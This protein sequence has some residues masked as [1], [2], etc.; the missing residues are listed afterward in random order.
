LIVKSVTKFIAILVIGLGCSQ[1]L[2]KELP[3]LHRA[4]LQA[5]LDKTRTLL[6][7]KQ[8]NNP[9]QRDQLGST[10][11]HLAVR[12]DNVVLV[13]LLLD[14]GANGNITDGRGQTAMDMAKSWTVW[15]T[16]LRGGALPG[17]DTTI[18]LIALGL[19]VVLG[20]SV[21]LRKVKT[22][23]LLRNHPEAY[24][25]HQSFNDDEDFKDAA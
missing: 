13:K 1:V 12:H 11:L 4:V 9:N 14:E 5:D 25:H 7:D 17:I 8:A 10:P 3:A 15:W 22:D 24:K 23:A 2:A 21:W 19:L 6:T 18:F 20:L 16:L